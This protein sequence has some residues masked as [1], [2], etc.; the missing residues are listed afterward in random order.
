[1]RETGESKPLCISRVSLVVCEMRACFQVCQMGT[2]CGT[3]SLTV[4]V[5]F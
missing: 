2:A 3:Q 1:M 5:C 4:C